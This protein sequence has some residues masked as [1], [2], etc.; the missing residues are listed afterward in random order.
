MVIAL[1]LAGCGGGGDPKTSTPATTSAPPP[2]RSASQ[3][4][5][6]FLKCMRDRGYEVTSPD[7]IHSAPPEVLQECFGALHESP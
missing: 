1:A 6:A 5:P 4:P 3:L 7:Q 2:S